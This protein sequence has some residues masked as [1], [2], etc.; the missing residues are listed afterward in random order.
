MSYVILLW[1]HTQKSL[2]DTQKKKGKESQHITTKQ[3]QWIIKKTTK[4]EKGN[5]TARD[6]PKNFNIGG[7]MKCFPT[8]NY[9]IQ[10]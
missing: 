8:N 4:E 7:K 10:K 3:N 2:E 9:F 5:E 6:R 1:P